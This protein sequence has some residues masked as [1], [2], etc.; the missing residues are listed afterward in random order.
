MCSWTL[1]VCG[2]PN[3][4]NEQIDLDVSPNDRLETSPYVEMRTLWRRRQDEE[5]EMTL[6]TVSPPETM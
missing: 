5:Q 2:E 3:A 4:Q 6:D 1:V